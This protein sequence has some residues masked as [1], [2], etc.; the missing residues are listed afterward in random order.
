MVD[1]VKRIVCTV[2]M[3]E[4][5]HGRE[6]GGEGKG[7]SFIGGPEG[8]KD[9]NAGEYSNTWIVEVLD[10]SGDIDTI[11]GTATVLGDGESKGGS[12]RN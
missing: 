1:G 6:A 10:D 3:G 7:A 12:P 11:F 4:G 8:S 9:A 2:I 5:S